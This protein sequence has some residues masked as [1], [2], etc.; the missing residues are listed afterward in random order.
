[1][2]Y[3]IHQPPKNAQARRKSLAVDKSKYQ[4]LAQKLVHNSGQ[5]NRLKTCLGI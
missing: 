4:K 1:M 3:I 2:G 5:I